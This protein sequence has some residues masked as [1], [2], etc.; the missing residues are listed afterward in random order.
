MNEPWVILVVIIG[1]A[2]VIGG[3][4]FLIYKFMGKK[5]P[6]PEI[7]E[8]KIAEEELERILEPVNDEEVAK[9]IEKYEEDEK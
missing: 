5:N 4:S 9:E 8:D 7:D 6:S 3:V 2:A 1:I